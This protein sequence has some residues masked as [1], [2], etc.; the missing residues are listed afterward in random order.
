MGDITFSSLNN[1]GGIQQSR[2]DDIESLC[3]IFIYL[4]KG[5][6][7]WKGKCGM[8]PKLIK[9]I[10]KNTKIND[11]CQGIPIEFKYF[12]EH[13]RNLKFDEKPD[14]N[15]FRKIFQE[16]FFKKGYVFDFV[17]DWI[18][19]PVHNKNEE[20]NY[21]NS[22]IDLEINIEEYKLDLNKVIEIVN[23]KEREK[24]ERKEKNGENLN[25]FI[26]K[27]EDSFSS[28]SSKEIEKTDT[29]EVC[30]LF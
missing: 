3:Y 30:K 27:D 9:F 18:L 19:I 22:L 14:Y 4:I 21:L 23:K 13:A 6:L 12:L 28:N 25:E 8:E 7:P 10:K 15:Y 20:G 26:D 29:N 2:R 1:D 24:N 11:I 17:Y 16:L 5:N